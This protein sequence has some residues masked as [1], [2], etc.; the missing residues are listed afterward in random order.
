MYAIVAMVDLVIRVVWWLVLCQFV[1]SLLINFNVIPT[2]NQTF[3]AIWR[4][5][6]ALLDPI[7][8]PIRKL[9]PDTSPMDFSPLV[10]IVGLQLVEIGLGSLV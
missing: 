8:R 5:I 3:S 4:G 10:L 7:L 6:N 9:L 2:H 1:V